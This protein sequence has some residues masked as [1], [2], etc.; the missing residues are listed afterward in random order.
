M[1]RLLAGV[2]LEAAG[3][4]EDTEMQ[5]DFTQDILSKRSDDICGAAQNRVTPGSNMSV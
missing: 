4:Q 5:A 1:Q 3:F 2:L